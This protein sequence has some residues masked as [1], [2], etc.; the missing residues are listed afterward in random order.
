MTLRAFGP[1]CS[2]PPDGVTILPAG[3]PPGPG[4]SGGGGGLEKHPGLAASAA[5]LCFSA[6]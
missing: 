2:L 1:P 3:K 5:D 4:P 6:E